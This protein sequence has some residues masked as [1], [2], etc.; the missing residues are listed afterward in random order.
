MVIFS[1]IL[2]LTY[3]THRA[4]LRRG[5]GVC[6][7]RWRTQV[8]INLIYTHVGNERYETETLLMNAVFADGWPALSSLSDKER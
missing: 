2:R 7:I 4:L 3:R 8:A 5:V 1:N 6:R